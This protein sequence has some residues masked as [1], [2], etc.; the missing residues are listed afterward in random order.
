MEKELRIIKSL[1]QI[2]FA[3][4]KTEMFLK[5][6]DEDLRFQDEIPHSFERGYLFLNGEY[7]S[8]NIINS[9]DKNE[10]IKHLAHLY[11]KTYREVENAL[12][13]YD[14]AI[15]NTVIYFEFKWE[16]LS[17]DIYIKNVLCHRLNVNLNLCEVGKPNPTI[18]EKM[19][20]LFD[21]KNKSFYDMYSYFCFVILQTCLWY[22]ATTTKTTKYIRQDKKPTFFHEKKEIINVKRTKYI[23]TPIYD[24]NK[25]R[26]KNVEGLIK[27]RSGWTY[28]H[29]FQVH[30]HYRH[31]QDGKVI[32]IKSYIKGKGKE[33]IPQKIILNPKEA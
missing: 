4:D 16:F 14:E 26:I 20:E 15:K 32:F 21:D 23:T 27:R 11:H 3:S 25:I 24:M 19:M 8:K 6:Y 33:E 18:L 10:R 12:N 30:G 1:P 2:T 17:L 22:I 7:F 31:Y 9:S 13:Q 28:S 5:W 29:S